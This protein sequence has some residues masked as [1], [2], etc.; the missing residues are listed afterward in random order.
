MESWIWRCPCGPR[1]GTAIPQ[2]FWATETVA[3]LADFNGDGIPDLAVSNEACA[4]WILLGKGDGTFEP[5]LVSFA[6]GAPAHNPNAQSMVVVD[7]N[8]DGQP[9]L[10][11]VNATLGGVSVLTNTTPR[12]E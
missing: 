12:S 6:I 8:G 2:S 11:T 3:V 1:P 9:D 5:Q 7:F 4:V 10:A